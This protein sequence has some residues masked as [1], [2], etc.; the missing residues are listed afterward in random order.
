[1]PLVSEV[2][3]LIKELGDVVKSTREIVDAVNDGRKFLKLRH[4]EAE[5]DLAGLLQQMQRA[6]EGLASVTRIVGSFRFVVEPGT[7]DL[8][9]ARTDLVRFNDYVMHQR[10][11]AARLHG[12]IRTLKAQCDKVRALRDKLDARTESRAWGSMFE[13]IGGKARQRS[14]ELNSALSNFYADDQNMITLLEQM[15][16]LANAALDEVESAL[17]PPGTQNPYSVPVAASVLGTYAQLFK[18]SEAGLD[19]LADDLSKAAAAL[20]T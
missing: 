8:D 16:R 14:M 7:I 6:I 18:Q 5:G 3:A 2:A 9:A 15:F 17:G 11:H 12:E 20:R 10:E 1:M 4:P 19:A 13:L